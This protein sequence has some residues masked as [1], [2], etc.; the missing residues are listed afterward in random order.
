[1]LLQFSN[2]FVY[3]YYTHVRILNTTP[4]NP[5]FFVVIGCITCH[6]MK[7]RTVANK[8]EQFS[9]AAYLS[10][11]ISLYYFFS[12]LFLARFAKFYY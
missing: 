1:M 11:N 12:G 9:N 6:E 7:G 3:Y 4:K 10:H 8:Y 5:L 2:G